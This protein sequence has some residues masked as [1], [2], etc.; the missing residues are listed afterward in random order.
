MIFLNKVDRKVSHPSPR[1]GGLLGLAGHYRPP[2][3]GTGHEKNLPVLCPTRWPF[4]TECSLTLSTHPVA[5]VLLPCSLSLPP[6]MF[7]PLLEQMD[8]LFFLGL[9]N[10]ARWD[11][12]QS[13]SIWCHIAHTSLLSQCDSATSTVFS[14]LLFLPILILKPAAETIQSLESLYCG[15]SLVH[16]TLNFSVRPLIG[17]RR[18]LLVPY[19]AA[20]AKL[21][22]CPSHLQK[23]LLIFLSRHYW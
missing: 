1:C 3:W 5:I 13:F 21:H 7:G 10:L 16:A 2:A 4:A 6:H 14:H 23:K 17:R 12:D 18:V 20:L 8:S 11:V 22:G 19:S 15:A 9:A